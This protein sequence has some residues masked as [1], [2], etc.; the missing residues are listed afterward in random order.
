MQIRPM[1]AADLPACAAIL[2]SVYNNDLWQDHWQQDTAEQYLAD[3]FENRKFVGYVIEAE[4]ILG[5]I[6]T[7]EKVWWNNS[8]VFVEEM[9]VSPAHQG[10]GLG[11]RL[12]ETVLQYAREKGLAGVTLTTNR[13]APAPKFYQKLGFKTNDAVIWMYKTL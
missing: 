7:R 4:T 6:F 11:T 1:R 13:H 5:A 8:E 3:Y 12:M 10:Q 2:C 9:F